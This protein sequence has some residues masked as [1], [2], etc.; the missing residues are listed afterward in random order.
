MTDD[1]VTQLK[2]L[3]IEAVNVNQNANVNGQKVQKFATGGFP[4][5][6]E[7]FIAREAG[8]ELVG[9][10]G[11]RTAVANNDQIVQA[12]SQGV[13]QAVASVFQTGGQV[14]ENVLM[15]DGDVIYKNQQQVAR[16]RGTDFGMG[17]FAR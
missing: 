3:A 13:A 5:Q 16:R 12:V 14:I 11:G 1:I 9:S 6:G 10:I 7:M 15:L 2:E 17:V 4:N 8:A